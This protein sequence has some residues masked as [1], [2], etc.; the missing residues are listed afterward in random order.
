MTDKTQL[1]QEAE[2]LIAQELHE[3][4]VKAMAAALK[5]KQTLTQPMKINLNS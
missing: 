3:T 5:K 1:E 2:A 4:K